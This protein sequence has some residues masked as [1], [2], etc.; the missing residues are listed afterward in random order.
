MQ[1]IDGKEEEELKLEEP[2]TYQDF[3]LRKRFYTMA[4]PK[5]VTAL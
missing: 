4:K 2:L 3:S 1:P 5:T